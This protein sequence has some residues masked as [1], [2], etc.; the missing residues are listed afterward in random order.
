VQVTIDVSQGLVICTF[1]GELID[2]D[3][4]GLASLL[5]SH[6]DLDPNFSEILDFSGITASSVSTSGV[7]EA[8]WRPSNFNPASMH[9]IIAPQDVI[10]GLARMS[11]VFAEKS[12]PNTAVVRTMDEARES[13]R[14]G[15][16]HNKS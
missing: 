12:R 3:L 13:I 6:P 4:L 16:P 1:S 7:Q 8:A 11:Q 9:V 14:A 2:A 15:R 10:F 5:R